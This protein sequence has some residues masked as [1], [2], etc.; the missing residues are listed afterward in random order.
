MSVST[1]SSA[2][3]FC[4]T[5][6]AVVWP[7]NPLPTTVIF[8]GVTAPREVGWAPMLPPRAATA[9]RPGSG[10]VL[11]K[12]CAGDP[13]RA[14]T[15]D[16]VLA[17]EDAARDVGSRG[18]REGRRGVRPRPPI[19][20]ENGASSPS[21]RRRR[22]SRVPPPDP[23]TAQARDQPAVGGCSRRPSRGR[24]SWC[25]TSGPST[26][27]IALAIPV[28]VVAAFV[29]MAISLLDE[30]RL[31]TLIVAVS[32][33]AFGWVTIFGPRTATPAPATRRPHTDRVDG[34]RRVRRATRTPS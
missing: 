5:R 6:I 1:T 13:P 33:A 7:T 16:H 27:L 34:G 11:R 20:P 30:R 29:G 8:M 26:Q 15:S 23:S 2:R 25:A 4:S 28:L 18:R 24:G 12:D 9:L 10:Q 17:T 14:D 31:S 22:R 19:P 32:V 3:P 21:P